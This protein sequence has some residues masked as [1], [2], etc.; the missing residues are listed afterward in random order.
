MTSRGTEGVRV[1]P[2]RGK[3]EKRVRDSNKFLERTSGE[4]SVDTAC[5][6]APRIWGL[7]VSKKDSHWGVAKPRR[8]YGVRVGEY[9]VAQQE[10]ATV[11]CPTWVGS[12]SGKQLPV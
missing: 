12:R 9:Y 2:W 3:E 1:E 8:G 4:P 6:P 10:R 7:I 11:R 5:Q